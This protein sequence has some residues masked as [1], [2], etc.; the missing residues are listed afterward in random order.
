MAKKYLIDYEF[1]GTLVVEAS[2]P[3]AAAAHALAVLR[4][5]S[6]ILSEEAA[7]APELRLGSPIDL[8]E[9]CKVPA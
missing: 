7:D 4:I 9:K 6:A 5:A 2:N 3:Q 8:A 1:Y